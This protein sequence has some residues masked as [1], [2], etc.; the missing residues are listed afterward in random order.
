V[1]V[2]DL[3]LHRIGLVGFASEIF[4]APIGLS[5]DK[6]AILSAIDAITIRPGTNIAAA[7]DAAHDMLG[8][9]RAGALPVMILMSDGSP[10]SPAPDPRTAAITSANFAK[11]DGIEIYA[12][13]LGRD[14][15]ASLMRN[16]ATDSGKYYYA[17]DGAD[18]SAIYEEIAVVV[19][20]S[21]VRDLVLDDDLYPDVEFVSG[22]DT[23][24]ATVNGER[25]RWQASAVPSDGLTWV[26]EVKP[27]KPGT[28]PTNERAVAR[29]RNADG[30]DDFFEFPRPEITVVDPNASKTC[31]SPDAWTVMVHS[32]PDT[33]G[34]SGGGR[35][36]CNNVFDSGDWFGGTNPVLP[37]LEYQLTDMTGEKVLA[38][39]K[40]VL[41]PGRVDQRVNLRACDPPPYR[42]RLTT[43]DLGGYGLCFNSPGDRVITERDFRRSFLKSTEERF[44]FVPVVGGLQRDPPGDY[45]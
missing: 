20:A 30:S 31:T 15:D 40:G 19:G 44:G 8:N 27:T 10:N 16:I 2:T 24:A 18:L 14:A 43:T 41:G 34:L 39:G 38:Q 1:N 5:Q 9:R 45:P 22:T 36:G 12:I 11:L 37:Q 6:D 13:G 25:L 7:I 26:Y 33:V 28:Y 32:F 21:V 4:P 3:G 17:P 23:P 42:L 35:P 29:F